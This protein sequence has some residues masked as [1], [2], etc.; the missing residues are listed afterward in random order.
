[1][2]IK[3]AQVIADVV[4]AAHNRGVDV[5]VANMPNGQTRLFVDAASKVYQQ[6]RRTILPERYVKKGAK[7]VGV[8]KMKRISSKAAEELKEKIKGGDAEA[9][10]RLVQKDGKF[11]IKTGKLVTMKYGKYQT[12][13]MRMRREAGWEPLHHRPNTRPKIGKALRAWHRKHKKDEAEK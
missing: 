6:K 7:Y 10:I 13:I 11:Y 3:S 8:W 5:L 12:L 9:R 2:D 1:M 4:E